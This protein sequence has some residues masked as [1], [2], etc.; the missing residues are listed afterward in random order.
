MRGQSL[1]DSRFCPQ[2]AGHGKLHRGGFALCCFP[3][4]A[5]QGGQ[6]R[7][8]LC[9]P[10]H[11]DRGCQR[12]SHLVGRWSVSP[13]AVGPVSSPKPHRDCSHPL[14]CCYCPCGC[15]CVELQL[16][17]RTA[18]C[19]RPA[20]MSPPLGNVRRRLLVHCRPWSRLVP[21]RLE[22]CV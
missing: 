6:C 21:P 15:D 12:D 9:E 18:P 4:M 2:P 17:T 14:R 16:F 8:C 5:R 7:F 3:G 1:G 10:P 22:V 11:V 19:P 13:P 20:E